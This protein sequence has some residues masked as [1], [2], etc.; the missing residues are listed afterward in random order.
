MD[1][2]LVKF[3][4]ISA[5]EPHTVW[6]NLNS[7]TNAKFTKLLKKPRL[8]KHH[9]EERLKCTKNIMSWDKEWKQVIF[10][11]EKKSLDGYK[12]YSHDLRK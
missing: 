9:Q 2:K 1:F 10:S 3:R 4:K 8:L 6:K 12:H 5:K 11:D 7:N